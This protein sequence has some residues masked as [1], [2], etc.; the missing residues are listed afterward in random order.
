[1]LLRTEAINL[2]A[3]KAG[4]PQLEA[5]RFMEI[6]LYKLSEL[7]LEGDHF[8]I[9]DFGDFVI[10]SQQKGSAKNQ[11]A[12]KIFLFTPLGESGSV[13]FGAPTSYSASVSPLDQIFTLGINRRFIPVRGES[14]SSDGLPSGTEE[15]RKYLEQHAGLLLQEGTFL[16]AS[17]PG[18]KQPVEE[19]ELS[20]EAFLPF[21]TPKMNV[22]KEVVPEPGQPESS[23]KG[24]TQKRTAAAWC[25]R[26]GQ[27]A[28][29]TRRRRSSRSDCGSDRT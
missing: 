29:P 23:T 19:D 2:L 3:E 13:T 16:R 20:S 26:S 12:G 24:L 17:R 1:M 11:A 15:M 7:L 8:K 9:A 10:S 25:Q 27:V 5:A 22:T 18:S 14:Y 21:N 28:A 4:V 6:F